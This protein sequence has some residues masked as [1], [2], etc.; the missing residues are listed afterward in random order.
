MD[1][2][3]NGLE[4][5]CCF[6]DDILIGS[7]SREEHLIILNEVLL[8]LEVH[9]IKLKKNK[10]AFLKPSITYLGYCIDQDGIN[11]AKDKVKAINEAPQPRDATDLRA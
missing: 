11:P 6:I 2:I 1:K 4:K 9:G 8:R 10:C 5:V 3:L 7:S